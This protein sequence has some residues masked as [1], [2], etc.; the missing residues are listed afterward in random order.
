MKIFVNVKELTKR[1]ITI[2]TN[3]TDSNEHNRVR[4]CIAKR[5]NLAYYTKRFEEIYKKHEEL[6]YI[7]SEL[8]DERSKLTKTMLQQIEYEH[9][10]IVRDLISSCL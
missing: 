8:L 3:M 2:W 10:K 9:G 6:G 1:Q 7:T 5:F 4:I